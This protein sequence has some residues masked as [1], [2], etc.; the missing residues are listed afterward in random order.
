MEVFGHALSG[1]A[2]AQVVR[3]DG[4]AGKWFW[5]VTGA[6]FALAPDIDAVTWLVGGPELFNAHH[7]YY[8]HNLLVFA[9]VPP[10][11]A[12]GARRFAP[13]GT[14]TPRV[15]AL[16]W[17]AWALHL[18][19]DTIAYRPV[20]LFWPFS[21]GGVALQ[22]LQRDFSLGIPAILLVGTGLSFVDTLVPWRRG[23]A[24]AT[25]AAVVAYL[26]LGPGW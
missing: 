20:K 7:Q 14:P 6:A 16:V 23:I 18:L 2:L 1:I 12:L 21:G 15:V 11:A 5:P 4:E 8:T 13:A 24:A 26:G 19:G 25:L 22:L 9:T 17:G 10:L 3:P